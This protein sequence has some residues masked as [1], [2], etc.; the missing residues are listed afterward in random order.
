MESA[1]L[2]MWIVSLCRNWEEIFTDSIS[3]LHTED[4]ER[5]IFIGWAI[6]TSDMNSKS[7]I[8]RSPMQQQRKEGTNGRSNLDCKSVYSSLNICDSSQQI[9]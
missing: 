7:I 8:F 3:V 9:S 6:L 5:T 1:I 4:L 2:F